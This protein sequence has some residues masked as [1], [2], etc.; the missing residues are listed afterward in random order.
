MPGWCMSYQYTEYDEVVF[1]RNTETIDAFSSHVLPTK[2]KKAYMGECIN[3]MTQALQI[4]DGSLPQGLTIQ[5]AYTELQGGSKNVGMVVR[6]STT[7][8]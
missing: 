7:Y 1:M 3:I 5:N 2:V 8:P 6:N 4:A